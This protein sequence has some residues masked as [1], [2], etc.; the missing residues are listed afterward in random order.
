MIDHT[1]AEDTAADFLAWLNPS[2]CRFNVGR[3]GG[4]PELDPQLVAGA[5]ALVPA[6]LG[7]DL[8]VRVYWSDGSKRNADVLDRQL[9]DAQL[10][11]WSARESGLYRALARIATH[12]SKEEKAAAT[13]DYSNAHLRRWPK[14]V[15]KAEP[16]VLSETYGDIRRVVLEEVTSPRACG[17][18]D[19][20]GRVLAHGKPASCDRCDGRGTRRAG[21]TW[22]AE[23]LGMKESSFKQTWLGPY[24]WLYVLVKDEL[25]EAEQAFRKALRR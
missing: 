17:N 16:V 12:V 4:R 18:C 19:G 20:S 5:L 9:L 21:P 3:G 23:R 11:E 1:D 13:R 10:Q 8:L 15:V 25:A 22:R 24:E 14:W 6:G 2:T 7:R